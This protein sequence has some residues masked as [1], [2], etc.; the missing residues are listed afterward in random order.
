LLAAAAVVAVVAIV[1]AVSS[2][3][4]DNNGSKTGTTIQTGGKPAKPAPPPVA[5]V[6]VRDGAAVG[7]IKKIEVK[8]GDVVRLVVTSDAEH[9]VHVHGYDLMKDT[10]PGKPAEFRFKANLEGVFEAELED[11]KKQIVKLTVNPS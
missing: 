11:L 8:K 1:I 7:G 4:D 9:E 5:R 3:G 6:E 10:A 2:G